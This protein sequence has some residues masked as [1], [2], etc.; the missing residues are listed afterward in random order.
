MA[1]PGVGGRAVVAST[2]TATAVEAVFELALGEAEEGA[3]T[4]AA[5]EPQTAEDLLVL[6]E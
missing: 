2:A 5:E 1:E 6:A 4:R 3:P